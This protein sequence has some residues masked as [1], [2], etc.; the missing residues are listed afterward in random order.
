[1]IEIIQLIIFKYHETHLVVNISIYLSTCVIL[2]ID[3]ATLPFNPRFPVHC[4]LKSNH[5]ISSAQL[6]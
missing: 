6:L 1:M 5:Y 3:L 4:F 2:F